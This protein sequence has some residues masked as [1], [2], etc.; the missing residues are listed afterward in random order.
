MRTKFLRFDRLKSSLGINNGMR[1]KNLDKGI[2]ISKDLYDKKQS[3][4]I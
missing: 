3:S 4:V 1:K 2:N